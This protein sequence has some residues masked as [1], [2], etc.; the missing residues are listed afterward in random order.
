MWDILTKA[1][2]KEENYANYCFYYC[3]KLLSELELDDKYTPTHFLL[4]EKVLHKVISDPHFH[5]MF[6]TQ[7][8]G[9]FQRTKMKF[10]KH[11]LL[12]RPLSSPFVMVHDSTYLFFFSTWTNIHTNMHAYNSLSQYIQ[13]YTRNNSHFFINAYNSWGYKDL[14][15]SC[16]PTHQVK[17]GWATGSWAQLGSEYLKIESPQPFSPSAF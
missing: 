16:G 11:G 13:A 3:R 12:S 5:F 6:A 9:C 4:T 17:T 1:K 15:R 14:W 8:W 7:K 2:R 10:Q